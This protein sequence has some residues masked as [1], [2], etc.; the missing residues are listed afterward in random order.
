MSAGT[1]SPNAIP[2]RIL[3]PKASES[4]PTAEGP[5]VQ[6]RSPAR[7]SSANIAV[8]PFGMRSDANE[9]VPGHMMPTNSPTAPQPS[10]PIHGC[11]AGAKAQRQYPPTQPTAAAMSAGLMG[12][13]LPKSEKSTRASPMHTANRQGPSRSPTVLFTPSPSSANADAH[14][15]T[16]SSAA[17]AQAMSTANSQK[18]RVFRSCGI[19]QR[20]PLFHGTEEGHETEVDGVQKRDRRPDAGEDEPISMPA[21]TKKRVDS[22]TTPTCPQQ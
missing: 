13:R 15:L 16:A 9:N 7:A 3:P 11:D 1:A 14:W 2:V 10:S 18:E 21:N 12:T 20:L 4:A 6:P 19:A 17:P 22:P 8:P 5:A